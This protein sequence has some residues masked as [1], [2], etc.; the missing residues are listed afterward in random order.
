MTTTS[1]LTA[2]DLVAMLRAGVHGD[3]VTPD[4]ASF[5]AAAFGFDLSPAGRPELV[6]IAADAGDVRVRIVRPK[7]ADPTLPLILYMH[8][9]GWVLGNAATHDRLVR[10]LACGA[11]AALAFVEYGRFI[12][13]AQEQRRHV[14][15]LVVEAPADG[16][17]GGTARVD[18]RACAVL[19]YDYLVMAGTQGMRNHQKTDRLLQ[20]AREQRLP[21][22]LFAEGGGGRP[23]DVDMPIVAA[24]AALLDGAASVD[25]VL[26]ALLSRP[27]RPESH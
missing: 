22:V 19:S 8:G 3:V 2:S 1:P 4:D 27:T 5:P 11:G 13:P 9:G 16:L 17:V 25:A 20:V 24:V 6:V 21:V 10:E 12:T 15:E 26:E 14:A 18:G 7:Y 23:G